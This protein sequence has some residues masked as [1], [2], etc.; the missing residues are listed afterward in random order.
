MTALIDLKAHLNLEHDLDDALLTSKIAT[1]EG[2]VARHI[3]AEDPV[4]YADAPA[5]LKEAVLQLAAHYYENREA[6]LVGVSAQE[7]PFGFHD[8][9]RPFRTWSF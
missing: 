5:P 6:S 8:L 4:T 3:G 9:V 7:L 2:M 1:A